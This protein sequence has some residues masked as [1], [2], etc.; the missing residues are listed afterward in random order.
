MRAWKLICGAIAL[1]AFLAPGAHADQWNKKT[2]LTF[3]APVQVPGVTLPAGTYTF[4][5][6]DPDTTRHVIRVSEKDSGKPL[7]LFITIP[8][9]RLEPPNDN[10]IMFAERPAGAPQAIQAWFYPGD[11][12]GEE[13]VY[14]KSQA[15]AIAKANRKAV[16]ATSDE[17]KSSA[18]ESERMAAMKSSSVSRVDESG[19]MKNEPA[20]TTAQSNT[21]APANTA[22][23]SRRSRAVGTTGAQSTTAPRSTT[24]SNNAQS[25]TADQNKT[26]RRHLPRT[27]SNLSLFELL[28]GLAIFSGLAIRRVRLQA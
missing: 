9:D 15:M 17:S 4:E 22:T 1:T 28:S 7:A 21:A 14:P 10:L 26:G 13:F 3:S 8:Q 11:R 18:S 24:A 23:G 25:N 6:A 27:A 19:Q 5:L 20:T 2:Y 12:I 16:L